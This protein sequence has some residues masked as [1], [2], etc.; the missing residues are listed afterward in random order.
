MHQLAFTVGNLFPSHSCIGVTHKDL[1]PGPQHER[2][3]T[4]QLSYLSHTGFNSYWN[5]LSPLTPSK[6]GHHN[7]RYL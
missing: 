3:A 4:Y 2:W 1:N 7:S 5:E 6:H